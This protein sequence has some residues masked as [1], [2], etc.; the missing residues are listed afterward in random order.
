MEVSRHCEERKRRS[1]PD[2][3]LVSGL[4]RPAPKLAKAN[5]VVRSQ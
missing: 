2:I 1:N 4:L 3:L 5:F